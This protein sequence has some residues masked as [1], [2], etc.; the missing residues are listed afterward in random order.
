M[1]EYEVDHSSYNLCIRGPNHRWL[2]V[3]LMC[4]PGCRFDKKE[5]A[6]YVPRC[7]LHIVKIVI[8]THLNNLSK[9]EENRAAKQDPEDE[10][11]EESFS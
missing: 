1:T 3:R 6:W 8:T 9:A 4:I 2:H 11:L 7:W 5:K 10:W